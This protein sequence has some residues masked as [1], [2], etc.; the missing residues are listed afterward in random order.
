MYTLPTSVIIQDKEYRICEKGDYKMILDCFAALNDPELSESDRTLSAMLIFYE[1]IEDISCI[2][3]VFAIDEAIKEAVEKMF[4]FFNCNKPNVGAS[5]LHKLIDWEQDEQMICAA[6]NNVAHTEIRC[7]PYIHWWTF[8]G[9]YCSV[10]ESTLAT[11]CS[12]R[13]KILT[14][15]KLEKYE[16]EFKKN[17]PEYFVWNSQ[18]I[19]QKKDEAILKDLWEANSL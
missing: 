19:Q 6:I 17:N 13:N 10:G 12:I 14:G 5:S 11:V 2:S 3:T 4:C 18:T 15:K 7:E 16:Q 1:D 9:Y 8:M